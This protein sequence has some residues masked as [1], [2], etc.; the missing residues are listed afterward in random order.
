MQTDHRARGQRVSLAMLLA[1]LLATLAATV[2]AACGSSSSPDAASLLQQTFGGTHK[3]NSGNVD[4]S[5]TIV[6][7]GSSTTSAPISLSFGGPFQSVG[8]KLPESD[9]NVTI[10]ALG[11]SGSLGIV[12]TGTAGYVTLQGTSYRL[13]QATFQKLES[14]FAQITSPPASGAGSGTLTKLGIQPLHWL[15]N[16]TVVGTENVGGTKT[17]HIRAGI[18]VPAFLNDLD[19]F[20]RKASMVGVSG[21]NHLS[22]GLSPA[23]RARIAREVQNPTFDVWT[24]SSDKTLRKMSI[25]LSL[26]VTGQTAS[27]LGGVRSAAIGLTVQYANL[28]QPQ[29]ITAP[30]SVR[31]FSEFTSKVRSFQQ[32][33]SASLGGTT[34]A[35]SGVAANGSGTSTTGG[36]AGS[37]WS[38]GTAS[39]VQNY[40]QCIQ[41]A[42]NDVKK[43][44]ECAPLV[45]SG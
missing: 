27:L 2:L 41:N 18:N 22:G 3:V 37:G 34:G 29:T 40:S 12:S 11:Q 21:A 23:T 38:T 30:S 45:G 4:L 16:P 24:G 15:K 5:L 9:F 42:G 14:S 32:A 44:Q 28:N 1:M 31:P 13:P 20:L 19:T 7:S 8:G 36:S 39:N 25:N 6:P 26:S 43:M 10:R 33:L 35:A 17:T